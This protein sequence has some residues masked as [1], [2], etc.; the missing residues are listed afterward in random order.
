M[1]GKVCFPLLSIVGLYLGCWY[2][3]NEVG[4][5][6]YEHWYTYL[7]HREESVYRVGAQECF[8]AGRV[9]IQ[10]SEDPRVGSGTPSETRAKSI[11]H[12]IT[13]RVESRHK[14]TN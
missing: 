14:A 11:N 2:E 8:Q 12:L 6:Y 1:I 9:G 4:N 3:E 10:M 7:S 13:S 5:P